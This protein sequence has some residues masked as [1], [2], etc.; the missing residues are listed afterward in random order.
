M[1]KHRKHKR[2]YRGQSYF[3][4]QRCFMKKNLTLQSCIFG[5]PVY[6]SRKDHWSVLGEHPEKDKKKNKKKHKKKSISE[7]KSKKKRN[8]IN[9][10]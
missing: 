9:K 3:Y 4:G 2:K 5:I 6:D 8:K 7:K 1:I 10:R